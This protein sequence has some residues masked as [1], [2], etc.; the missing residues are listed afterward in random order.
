VPIYEYHCDKC[1]DFEVTQRITDEPLKKCPTCRAK[2]KKLISATSFQL[3][4]SG[5]YITDYGRSGSGKSTAKSESKGDSTGSDSK[6][7]SKSESKSETKTESK[8][9][10]GKATEKAAA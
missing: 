9:S 7:D 4:G 8:S 6:A 10:G 3:N 2:V 5:W 1:G